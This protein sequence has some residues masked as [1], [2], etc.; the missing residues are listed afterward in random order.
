MQRR[1]LL[2]LAFAGQLK[3]NKSNALT[4]MACSYTFSAEKTYIDK[5][6]MKMMVKVKKQKKANVEKRQ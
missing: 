6:K 4:V 2:V 1:R 3:A 5:D